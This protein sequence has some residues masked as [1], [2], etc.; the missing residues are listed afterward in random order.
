MLL[1]ELHTMLF[2]WK[3]HLL[4][5]GTVKEWVLRNRIAE[6]L[7][8]GNHYVVPSTHTFIQMHVM[9]SRTL[10]GNIQISFDDLT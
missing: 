4:A 7:K 5:L 8:K 3:E 9:Y 10:W 6:R 1:N 2:V